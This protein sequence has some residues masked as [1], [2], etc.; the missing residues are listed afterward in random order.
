MAAWNTV[1]QSS[2]PPGNIITHPFLWPYWLV[3]L[4]APEFGVF[5]HPSDVE[6]G[7]TTCFGQ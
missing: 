6:A 4:T 5:L 2:V 1:H 7:H 3:V